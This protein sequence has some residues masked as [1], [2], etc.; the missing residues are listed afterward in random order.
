[1]S[2][3]P[4]FV[5]AITYACVLPAAAQETFT[6]RLS[7]SASLNNPLAAV[8]KSFE[9]RGSSATFGGT[10]NFGQFFHGPKV[11]LFGGAV[12]NTPI[13]NLDLLVEYS[14]DKYLAER[15]SGVA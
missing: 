10:V 4:G 2:R 5:M 7:D 6:G 15:R 14:S 13:E 9:T 12:W 1:M 8:F 11:G 3:V